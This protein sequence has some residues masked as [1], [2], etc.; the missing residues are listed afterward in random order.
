MG[1]GIG[2]AT[3]ARILPALTVLVAVLLGLRWWMQRGHG[4]RP[5]LRVLTRATVTRNT[6]VAVVEVDGRRFLVGGGDQRL[7]LL[8]E[9]GDETLHAGES[10]DAGDDLMALPGWERS[11][12]RPRTGL[13]DQLRAWTVR[14]H[15]RR[16][17]RGT[18]L[19]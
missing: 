14:S 19:R 12:A 13:L 2:L 16:P 4:G 15:V 8:A 9:L 3:F 17:V 1:P 6:V 7:A 11:T 18:P 5:G 10:A